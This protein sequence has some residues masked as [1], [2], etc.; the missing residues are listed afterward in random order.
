MADT[1]W[2]HRW[3]WLF[4]PITLAAL[5]WAVWLLWSGFPA[6]RSNLPRLETGWLALVL[7]GS[8]L[9]GYL[10]FEA[11]RALFGKMRPDVYPRLPLAHLYFTGQL[12][13]HVPGR[14]WGVAYQVTA[15][16][17]ATSVQWISVTL[18]YM[19]LSTWFALWAA[20]A[21]LG[22]SVDWLWGVAVLVVGAVLYVFGWNAWLLTALLS[23]LRRLP[24]KAFDRLGN[25][26]APFADV[27]AAFKLRILCWFAANWSLYLLAWAGYGMAWP[28]LAAVD[29]VQL[30]ALYTLAWFVGYVSLVSPS[31]LGVR[32]L[33]F[34][35][36]A[37]RFPPDAVAGM[38]VLGRVTLLLVD[39]ILGSVFVPFRK[40]V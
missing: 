40:A 30:C 12:M 11:F 26:L 6:L 39:V 32:E 27:E 28:G 23:L 29:G 9:A 19:I 5:A 35:A 3:R 14:V 2:R 10:G 8:V 16:S 36:L 38:A 7:C 33:V 13:K 37:Y 20:T 4:L 25:A 31:G 15:G 17:G 21:V 22:W 18:A 24:W 34:V 1:T